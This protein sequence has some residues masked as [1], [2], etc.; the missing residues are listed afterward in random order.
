MDAGDAETLV[1]LVGRFDGVL[2]GHGVGDEQNLYRVKL[3][4]QL[5]Q[6]HHQVVI[7]VQ[8]AGG[9]DQQDIAAGVGGFAARE[10]ARSSGAVSP[11]TPS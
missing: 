10:R 11:G 8:A 7:D 3:L 9:I 1:E 5:L 2:A 6:L 4:F